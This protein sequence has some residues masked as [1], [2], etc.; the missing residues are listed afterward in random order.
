MLGAFALKVVWNWFPRP[1]RLGLVNAEREMLELLIAGGL[2]YLAYRIIRN[3]FLTPQSKRLNGFGILGCF[4]LLL[5][6]L[7]FA[8][9]LL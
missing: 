5:V 7:Y 3:G 8:M 1:D 6:G 4:V 9:R 2:L